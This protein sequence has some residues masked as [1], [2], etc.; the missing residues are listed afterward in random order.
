[1]TARLAHRFHGPEDGPVL[2]LSGSLGTTAEAVWGEQL[3]ALAKRHRVLAYDH[4]GH[5]ASETPPGPYSIE[6]LGRDL[7][8]LLDGLGIARVSFCGLSLGGM[9]GLWLAGAAPERVERLALLCTSARL[10]TPEG[11]DERI[12]AVRR[13]GVGSIADSVVAG[14][15]TPDFAAREPETVRRRREALSGTPVEGY[16]G[17]C[18]A[19]RDFDFSDRLAGVAAPALVV[20]GLQDTAAPVEHQAALAARIPQSRLVVLDGAAHLAPVEQ[21]PAVAAALLSHLHPGEGTRLERGEAVR[22]EVLGDAHVDAALAA[23]TPF[24]EDFQRYLTGAAWSDV[25]ARDGIDRRTRS[26]VT[27]TAL[28]AANRMEE[29]A[30]HVR[31]A[32]RNGLGAEEIGEVILNAAVY[33]GVPA[34]NDGFRVAAEALSGA[35]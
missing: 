14:W 30:L 5:G 2:V 10:G 7:L 19:I 22:R 12:A 1:M 23:T 20:S 3:P 27:L 28:L 13:G 26:A 29:F 16:L 32:R 6:D 31:A 18:A 9:V 17:C 35:T 24:T 4:R 25:W 8:D 11:W 21:G 33:L 15:F 34:A